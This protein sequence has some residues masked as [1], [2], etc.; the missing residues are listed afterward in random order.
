MEWRRENLVAVRE[1][2]TQAGIAGCLYNHGPL[3]GPLRYEVVIINRPEGREMNS[4]SFGTLREVY[5]YLCQTLQAVPAFEMA[6]DF[7][8]AASKAQD[9]TSKRP[10]P[11]LVGTQA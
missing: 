7:E 2:A 8:L 11:E 6:Q 5:Y 4:Q 1:H 10:C 9:W 3:A